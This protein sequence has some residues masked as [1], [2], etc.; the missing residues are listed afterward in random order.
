MTCRDIQTSTRTR[1]HTHT[2]TQSPPLWFWFVYLLDCE[3]PEAGEIAGYHDRDMI[4]GREAKQS[5]HSCPS[6]HLYRG[7]QETHNSVVIAATAPAALRCAAFT[8]SPRTYP[9]AFLLFMHTRLIFGGGNND[10]QLSFLLLPNSIRTTQSS[11]SVCS[12]LCISVQLYSHAP[13]PE[14]NALPQSLTIISGWLTGITARGISCCRGTF[15]T[16]MSGAPM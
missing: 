6:I 8:N 3:R 4:G 7:D 13:V 15:L 1:T 12:C 11:A 9:D 5:F 10:F 14:F 2:H 16:R